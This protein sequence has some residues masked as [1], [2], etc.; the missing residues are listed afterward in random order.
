MNLRLGHWVIGG[1]Q[2]FLVARESQLILQLQK[3][4]S[5]LKQK[6]EGTMNVRRGSLKEKFEVNVLGN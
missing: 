3:I 2:Q 4:S 6:H 5:K 1:I